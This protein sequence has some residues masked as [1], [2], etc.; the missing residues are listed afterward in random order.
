M[1]H[2]KRA[3]CFMFHVSCF[4][5]QV[6]ILFGPPGAGKGTQ[7]E[8]LSEKLGLFFLESSKVIE[9]EFKKVEQLPK[10]S[11][12]RTIEC[13]GEKFDILEETKAWKQGVLTSPPVA[14][15]WMMRE[16]K[17]IF[18]QGESLMLSGSPRT[19]YEAEKEMPM[20]AEL[21]GKENIKIVLIEISAEV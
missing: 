20:L 13:F 10:D 17:L 12:E 11:P 8:L 2:K 21:Y 14:T 4:M 5:K 1:K 18:D 16:I 19:V 15:Y 9:R 3:T 6:V 7:S